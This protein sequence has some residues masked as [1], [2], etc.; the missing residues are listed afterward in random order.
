M[1]PYISLRPGVS[2]FVTCA[3]LRKKQ[4]LY[5]HVKN[6]IGT[7][8][9]KKQD[10]PSVH[11]SRSL[12]SQC[13]AVKSLPKRTNRRPTYMEHEAKS[14]CQFAENK[15]PCEK[16]AT[17]SRSMLF[18]TICT[19]CFL[20][21]EG[22]LYAGCCQQW[23]KQVQRRSESTHLSVSCNGYGTPLVSLSERCNGSCCSCK[24]CISE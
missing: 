13:K 16:K 10:Q 4:S 8:T 19:P 24:S 23:E 6:H 1:T 17:R 7:A 21:A 14:P 11:G 2:R 3:Y 5:V 22:M 20:S 12:G 15:G 18:C 9:V